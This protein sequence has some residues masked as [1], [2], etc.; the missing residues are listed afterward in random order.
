MKK[1]PVLPGF[2]SKVWG[3]LEREIVDGLGDIAC[4]GYPGGAGLL[5]IAFVAAGIAAT[6]AFGAAAAEELNG[7]HA[8]GQGDAGGPIVFRIGAHFG[9]SFCIYLSAFFE[10]GGD[11]GAVCPVSTFHPNGL[12]FLISLGVTEFLG[13]GHVEI[14]HILSIH[15]ISDTVFTQVA[16]YLELYHNIIFLAE[17]QFT[18]FMNRGGKKFS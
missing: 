2:S 18:A 9:R 11:A 10:I 17:G 13:V 16:D 3:S 8:Q 4:G 12:I 6:A 7:L 14:D 1:T 5:G 15:R